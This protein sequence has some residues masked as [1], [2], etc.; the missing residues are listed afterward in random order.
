MIDYLKNIFIVPMAELPFLLLALVISFTIHEFAHAYAAWKFGDPTAKLLGRVSLYPGKH[1][2]YIG[3]LLF[4]ILG[5]GWARPVPVNRNH[6]KHPRTMSIIVSVV[7]PLS[8]LLLV[9]MGVLLWQLTLKY[10]FIH[11]SAE[12]SGQRAVGYFFHAFIRCNLILC[13]FN[14]LPV[15]PLDGYRII[16]DLSPTRIRVRLQR[17]EQWLMFIFLIIILLPN[18][19]MT[20]LA[21]VYRLGNL[22]KQMFQDLSWVIIGG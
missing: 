2:D 10:G 6:F 13:L 7:G 14:L 3:L 18:L 21:P 22:I 11:M 15:P 16:E 20:F 8:N 1:I 9:F 17:M 4:V 5:F 12:S 19:R